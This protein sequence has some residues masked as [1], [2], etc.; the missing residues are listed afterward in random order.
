VATEIALFVI[1]GISLAVIVL[2]VINP[3][4]FS[5]ATLPNYAATPIARP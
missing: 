1:I 2:L 3:G 5:P 4:I